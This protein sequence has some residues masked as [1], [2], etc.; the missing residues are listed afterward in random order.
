[1]PKHHSPSK[2]ALATVQRPVRESGPGK[3]PLSSSAVNARKNDE[4]P[5]RWL[6][7]GLDIGVANVDAKG[8][9]RYSNAR[10]AETLGAAPHVNLSGASLKQFISA[11]SWEALD[12]GLAG[13][14]HGALEGEMN[15]EADGK[16]RVVRLSLAPVRGKGGEISISIVAQEVTALVEASKALHDS[17]ASVHSLS[18]RILKVQDEERRRIARELHDNTGQE[19]AIIA[20]SLDQLAANPSQPPENLQKGI[21]ECVALVHKVEDE[22]RTLSYLLHPPLLDQL[23]LSAAL[24][25]YG[26][27]FTKRTG[28]Q[29]EVEVPQK[30]PRFAADKETALFRVVQEA[31]SNVLRHSGSR[32]ARLRFSVHNQVAEIVV[33]DQGKGMNPRK[34]AAANAGRSLG[35]GIGGMRERL[36]QL[37]GTLEIHSESVGTRIVAALPVTETPTQESMAPPT[38]EPRVGRER[39]VPQIGGRRRILI[40]DDHEVTRRGIRSLFANELDLEICGEAKDGIE[41][42]AKAKELKPDL[43]LLDLIMPR[44]GGFSAAHRLRECGV[45][46]R[47]LVFTTHAYP[48][49]ERTLRSAGCD[50]YVLKGYASEDLI[51]GVRAVLEGEFVTPPEDVLTS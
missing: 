49:L 23:G 12:A 39:A 27:G 4:L 48:G 41:V 29:I 34:V 3:K 18:A 17:E 37:G 38:E 22:I 28:I 6:L 33:E 47:I 16:T 50:G 14:V 31:L 20:I 15:V 9:I 21:H 44:S 51:R 8:L 13:A 43:I 42:V 35:V 30:S 36:R 7:D 2:S 40:A 24:R 19:L 26:E 11:G 46:S 1:V 25:W 32:T 5:F 45:Q 10:F